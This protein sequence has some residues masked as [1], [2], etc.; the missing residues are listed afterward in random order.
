LIKAPGGWKIRE[1]TNITRV[2][3]LIEGY[4]LIASKEKQERDRKKYPIM[5]KRNFNILSSGDL[6]PGTIGGSSSTLSSL[7]QTDKY[8][9][10]SPI[11]KKLQ[12][13]AGGKNLE[14]IPVEEQFKMLVK[15]A[16]LTDSFD[17][18]PSEFYDQEININSSYLIK[19]KIFRL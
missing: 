16:K 14:Q 12:S 1:S 13:L 11:Q 2:N 5:K 4:K 3:E 17:P 8:G 7:M 6:T 18:L 9:I 10:L 15:P 19:C